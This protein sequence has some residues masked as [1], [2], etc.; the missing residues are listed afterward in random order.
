VEA[1]GIGVALDHEGSV[2]RLVGFAV[3]RAARPY[4]RPISDG[5]TN[6]WPSSSVLGFGG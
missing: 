3:R 6:R 1:H 5:S 2:A 4:P